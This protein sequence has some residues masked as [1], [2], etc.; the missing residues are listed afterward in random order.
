MQKFMT[1]ETLQQW[2]GTK[3][4]CDGAPQVGLREFFT[5]S[6]FGR[7]WR[8]YQLVGAIAQNESKKVSQRWHLEIM[9][10]DDATHS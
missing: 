1:Q 7:E 4:D 6:P 10:G 5:Q 3:D 2:D 8:H 9:K